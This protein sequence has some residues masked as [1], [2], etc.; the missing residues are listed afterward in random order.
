MEDQQALIFS[1]VPANIIYRWS[2][3]DSLSIFLEPSGYLGE[4][5][6]KREPG[7]NGLAL[8]LDG[9]LLLCQHGQRQVGKLKSSLQDLKPE[10]ETLAFEWEGKK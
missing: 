5:K 4:R 6:D 3:L 1:D 2:E 7:S 10:Y 9:K 8:D